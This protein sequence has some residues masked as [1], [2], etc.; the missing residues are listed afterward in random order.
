[1]SDIGYSFRI[2]ASYRIRRSIEDSATDGKEFASGVST[3][4]KIPG[5]TVKTGTA[6]LCCSAAA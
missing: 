2:A 4:K 6:S 1:M 5:F 3:K